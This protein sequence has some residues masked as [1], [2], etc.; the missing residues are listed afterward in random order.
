MRY[1]RDLSFFAALTAL[2]WYGATKNYLFF[3]SAVE[4]GNIAIYLFVGFLGV[5]A[6]RMTPDPFLQGLSAIYFSMSFVTA[7]HT[8]AYHGTGVFPGWTANEPTQFWMLMRFIQGAGI[9]LVLLFSTR[10]R[11]TRLFP[12]GMAAFTLGGVFLVFAGLFPDCFT[13]GA[14][15]TPFKVGGEYAVALLLVVSIVYSLHAR[16]HVELDRSHSFELSLACFALAGMSFT[17]YTDVYGFFNMLGHVLHGT[18]RRRRAGPR[19]RSWPR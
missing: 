13:P 1:G 4:L 11:F 14:G 18:G 19:V 10:P 16:R 17:L 9:P 5:F 8:L 7:L 12:A 3:H 2:L 15:P 6:S